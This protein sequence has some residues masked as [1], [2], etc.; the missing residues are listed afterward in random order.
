MQGDKRI[1]EWPFEPNDEGNGTDGLL[2]KGA[3]DWDQVLGPTLK[4]GPWPYTAAELVR[5]W[6]ALPT[7][8]AAHAAK[9]AIFAARWFLYSAHLRQKHGVAPK[10]DPYNELKRILSA[11]RELGDAICAAS[12]EATE[13]LSKNLAS[14]VGK[15]PIEAGDVLST[16]FW[17]QYDN[18]FAFGNPLEPDNRIGAPHRTREETFI[19]GLWSAWGIAHAAH[20]PARGWPAFRTACVE[21]LTNARFPKELRSASRTPR[22]WQDLLRRAR[23]RFEGAIK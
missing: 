23:S 6:D 12:S 16:L 14:V 22:G 19:Y 7:Q 17:F 21:P 5:I 13:Y 3:W 8:G 15:R 2:P 4:F 18:R 20:L 9:E 10:A 11:S 1:S